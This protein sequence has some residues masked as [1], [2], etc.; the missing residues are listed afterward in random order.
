MGFVGGLEE[1]DF[2]FPNLDTLDPQPFFGGV[3]GQI[4]V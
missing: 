4:E 3:T 2:G 1:K